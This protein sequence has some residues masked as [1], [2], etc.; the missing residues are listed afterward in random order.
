MSQQFFSISVRFI[1][2]CTIVWSQLPPA[3]QAAPL[4]S[5]GSN[6]ETVIDLPASSEFTGSIGSNTQLNVGIGG[7]TGP[8]FQAG[9][10]RG[11]NENLEVNLRGGVIDVFS[12]FHETTLNINGGLVGLGSTATDSRVNLSSGFISSAF[13]ARDGSQLNV[14]GGAVGQALSLENDSQLNISGGAI[15]DSLRVSEGAVHVSGATIGP[16]FEATS[17]FVDIGRD[18]TVANDFVAVDSVVDVG[19]LGSI[20][21]SSEFISSTLNVALGEVGRFGR[22]EQGSTVNVEFGTLGD[23]F[24]VDESTINFLNGYIGQLGLRSESVANISGGILERLYSSSSTAN[25]SGGKLNGLGTVVDN[26]EIQLTVLEAFLDGE[27]LDLQSGLSLIITERDTTLSGLLADGSAFSF[28]LFDIDLF[29]EDELAA[30]SDGFVIQS[31]SSF[32]VVRAAVS[33]ITGTAILGD[34]NQDGEVTFADIP[35]FIEILTAETFFEEAD[36][37]QDGEVNFADIAPFSE[38]L[39]RS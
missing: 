21:N 20:G 7:N 9:S 30:I 16:D 6:F 28:D 2:L 3:A 32:S 5:S 27:E 36:C 19:W 1:A 38:I 31:G 10:L 14:T 34:C 4:Q 37:N 24:S 33:Q 17:S 39:M 12:S 22:A 35:A 15:G 8:L 18:G 11:S 29:D 23:V 25:I 26:S 13:S